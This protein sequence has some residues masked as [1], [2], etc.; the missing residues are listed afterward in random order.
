MEHCFR[1]CNRDCR[2]WTLEGVPVEVETREE[3]ATYRRRPITA[4]V[5]IWRGEHML[6]DGEREWRVV[7]SE[8]WDG[9]AMGLTL[10]YSV[11]E[12]STP[13]QRRENRRHLKALIEELFPGWTLSESYGM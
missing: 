1:N 3:S 5:T 13:A 9:G 4:K 10:T 6:Y 7:R 12:K 2:R 11:R 8:T